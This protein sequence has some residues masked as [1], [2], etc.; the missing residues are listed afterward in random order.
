MLQSLIR[1]WWVILLR[2]MAAIGFGIIAFIWPGITLITLLY[3]FGLYLI[4]DGFIALFTVISSWGRRE[5]KWLLVIDGIL[6]LA[7]GVV[8]VQSPLDANVAIVFIVGFWAI[9]GGIIKVA[10][11][12]HVRNEIKGEGWI[13]FSGVVTMLFGFVLIADPLQGAI[14]LIW[15]IGALSI[16]LGFMWVITAFRIRSFS[17]RLRY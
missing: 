6:S 1:N 17:S 7:V 2:G 15:L 4:V 16:A 3:F 12:I 5:D 13:A 9:M 14:S 10:F 8:A 11:A